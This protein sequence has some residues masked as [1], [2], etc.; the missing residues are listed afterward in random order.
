MRILELFNL[1]VKHNASDLHI[2]AGEPPVFRVAGQLAR[3]QSA[4]PFTGEDCESLLTPIMGDRDKQQLAE[5]GYCDFAYFVDGVGRFRC[6]L[7]RQLSNLSAAIRSRGFLRS[8]STLKLATG[9]SGCSAKGRSAT[10][11][12]SQRPHR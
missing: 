4:P 12:E 6:N 11:S 9:A 8:A 1:M 3:M 7:F 10:R 2:K 5:L